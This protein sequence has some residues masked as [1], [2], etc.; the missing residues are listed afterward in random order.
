MS[1]TFHAPIHLILF[2]VPVAAGMDPY[3][4]M[5]LTKLF[6]CSNEDVEPVVLRAEGAY[7][8]LTDGRHRTVASMMA[9]RRTVLARIEKEV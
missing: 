7:Y 9:G 3:V 8:T 5:G 1:D 2:P 4:L 6:R